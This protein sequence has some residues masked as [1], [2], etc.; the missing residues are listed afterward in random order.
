MPDTKPKIYVFTAS[1]KHSQSFSLPSLKVWASIKQDGE[2]LTA[3]C[4]CMA[5]LGEICSHVAAVLFTAEANTRTKAGFSS[6]SLPCSWLPKSF[7]FVPYVQVKD[8]DFKTPG[9][10]VDERHQEASGSETHPISLVSPPTQNEINQLFV[11]LSKTKGRP[12]ILSHATG[13][14]DFYIPANCLPDFPKPLTDLLTLVLYYY[15]IL[16]C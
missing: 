7:Q 12:V 16:T 15:V 11:N 1:V 2:I 3:H 4:T 6:T 13:F 5:G 14:N 10:K 9:L 8:M